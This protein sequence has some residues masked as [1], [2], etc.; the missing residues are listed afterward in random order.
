MCKL[1]SIYHDMVKEQVFRFTE[2]QEPFTGYEIYLACCLTVSN[3]STLGSDISSY[4][5]EL[6]NTGKFGP[7]WASTS[8][9]KDGPLLYFMIQP[10]TCVQ[11]G[12][13]GRKGSGKKTEGKEAA[14]DYQIKLTEKI[15]QIR[16]S[17]SDK[18]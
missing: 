18:V 10:V 7:W 15:L 4:V 17:L 13:P 3:K 14:V 1:D 2:K 9:D 16:R 11:I 8:I 6:Y 5:R 12:K